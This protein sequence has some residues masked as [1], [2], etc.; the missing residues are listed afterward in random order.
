MIAMTKFEVSFN[1]PQCGF[2]SIGFS[3][4]G[5][6]FHTTTANLPY[7]GALSELITILVGYLDGVSAPK[8][9]KWN[10]DPEEFDFGF[11][12]FGNELEIRIFEYPTGDRAADDKELR[13]RHRGPLREVCISFLATF[14]QLFEDRETD[15]FDFN[16][17]QPFP[18]RELSE[19]ESRLT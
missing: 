7:S 18:E 3:G 15:E 14:R 6:E 5:G 4:S 1:S 9:L 13:F 10:R 11:E 8:T 12:P 2:M 19:L 17:R 16:W